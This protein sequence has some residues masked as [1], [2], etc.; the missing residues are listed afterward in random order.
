MFLIKKKILINKYKMKY[1]FLLLTCT[2][3][4]LHHINQELVFLIPREEKW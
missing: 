1:A 4:H 2:H 3:Q